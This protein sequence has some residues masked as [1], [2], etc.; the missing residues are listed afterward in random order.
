VPRYDSSVEPKPDLLW[1]R[2]DKVSLDVELKQFSETIVNLLKDCPAGDTELEH[3]FLTA[4]NL[5]HVLRSAAVKVALVAMQGTGKSLSTNAIFDREGLSITGA[6]GVACTSAVIRYTHLPG[7]DT[8]YHAHIKF[9]DDDKR[10]AMLK[11]HAR[12]YYFYHNADDDEDDEDGDAGREQAD[13]KSSQTA[14]AVFKIIFGSM[15]AFLASWSAPTFKSGEFVTLCLFK[16]KD[17][18]KKHGVSSG[19]TLFKDADQPRD[20]MKQLKPFVTALEG[21]ASFAPLVDHVT[22][23]FSHELL[24]AGIEFIDLPGVSMLA[25]M[26]SD[27][28]LTSEQGGVISTSHELDMPKMSR[29]R[30]MPRYC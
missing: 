14:E 17:A 26:H 21:E 6:K 15:D 13:Q 20:L 11:E 4:P 3:L 16:C 22:I 5:R 2:L 28:E 1:W 7:G 9:L 8:S 23:S 18:L 10:E 29:T 25:C 30:S 27:T 19:N 24:E 12:N